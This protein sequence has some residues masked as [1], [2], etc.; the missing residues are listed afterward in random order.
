[1][2]PAVIKIVAGMVAVA[3]L[4][5]AVAGGA[6]AQPAAHDRKFHAHVDAYGGGKAC[7]AAWAH[8]FSTCTAHAGNGNNGVADGFHG[9]VRI[10]WCE[11]AFYAHTC[12]Y[13]HPGASLPH[14]YGRWM[15]LCRAGGGGLCHNFLLGAV[16]M[17]N[18]PF[19]IVAG[20][21]EGHPVRPTNTDTGRVEHNGG[22]LFLYVGFNGHE[23]HSRYGYVFGFRG[24]IHW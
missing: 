5:L 4:T 7:S 12:T 8:V 11:G 3:G 22:P 21:I 24:W 13:V 18:G 10:T 19:A 14:G 17:P 2:R 15:L 16:K 20:R 1:V 9:A 23:P 6:L